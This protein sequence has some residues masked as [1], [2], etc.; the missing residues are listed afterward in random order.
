M[1]TYSRSR[2]RFFDD[3]VT[4]LSSIASLG[5]AFDAHRV[6]TTRAYQPT[7]YLTLEGIARVSNLEVRFFPYSAMQILL[8]NGW[9]TEIY[10][11]DRPL[12]NPAP[13]HPLWLTG[14]QGLHGSMIEAA[15]VHYFETVRPVVEQNH[16][17]DPH[18]WPSVW[19]FARVVRN[20]F[21]HAGQI[22]FQNP[23]A[24]SVAWGSLSYSPA[25]NGRQILYQD[26][27]AV[28]II[29]LMEDMDTEV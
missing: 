28:E 27:T 23:A 21:A 1:L 13:P 14:L 16:G 12:G 22:T 2:H 3:L 19:D 9:P 4:F 17:A 29:L 18:N 24:P 25:D 15:F 6:G 5:I 10:L 8:A 11:D 20:A 26:V 7:D